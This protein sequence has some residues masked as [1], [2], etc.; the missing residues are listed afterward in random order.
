MA[1][2]SIVSW[3]TVALVLFILN[4]SVVLVNSMGLFEN[5]KLAPVSEW[6]SIDED[7]FQSSMRSSHA[8]PSYASPL[9]TFG[10]WFM[11]SG[12]L[13]VLISMLLTGFPALV[14]EVFMLP[15]IIGWFLKLIVAFIM[16]I[17]F[18]EFIS[19]RSVR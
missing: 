17:G 15:P 2:D 1:R 6:R 12:Y 3:S 7:W 11:A 8:L 9:V 5:V 4:L 16:F 13:L 10:N 14:E 18:I 19:G